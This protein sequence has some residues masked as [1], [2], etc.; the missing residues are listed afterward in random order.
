MML[1]IPV[2]I[3]F[4]VKIVSNMASQI[5]HV[6]YGQLV[7][8][9]FLNGRKNL[10]LR[11]FFIGTLFSDIRYRAK[12]TK[13]KTHVSI[14]R[15]DGLKTLQTSFQIGLHVHCLVDAE[16]ERV[17]KELG[18]YSIFPLDIFTSYAMK[19]VEDEFT[20]RRFTEW[21]RVRG[22]LSSILDEEMGYTSKEV[23]RDWH[24]GLQNYF[25]EEPNQKTTRAL[26]K[27]AYIP[28]DIIIGSEK[29]AKE[30]KKLES[31]MRII[32][33]TQDNLFQSF[34]AKGGS[35]LG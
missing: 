22:Y 27:L 31:A 8:D 21:E 28:D 32:E 19:F 26:A 7:L 35:T 9:K 14:N 18:F 16:R 34:F 29:R 20:Y 10:N 15:A 24:E 5:T 1:I 23:V 12:L 11:D 30:I 13:D 4:D 3:I 33:I 25:S 2:A 6:T 17:V